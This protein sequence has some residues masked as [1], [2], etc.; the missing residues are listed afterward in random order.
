MTTDANTTPSPGF[1]RLLFSWTFGSLW[2]L[3]TLIRTSL[4]NLL[5]LLVIV[6]VIS[7]LRHE[8]TAELPQ[9]TTLRL[10]PS[11]LLVDQRSY[12][13]P[14]TQLLDQVSAEDIETPVRDLVTAINYA[15]E[16]PRITALVLEPDALVGG[17]ISKLE[18]VG[19]ALQ[20]F[21]SS[22]KPIIARAD[23]FSQEQYYLA[24]YADEIILNPLGSVL[25]TGYSSYRN[26]FKTA[27]D[28]L[29]INYHVFRAGSYKDAIEPYTRDD[30]SIA[31]RE[32]N[33]LWL[34]Q[35]WDV[36][37]SRIEA[38]RKLPAGSIDHYI[39]EL[40]DK[41]RASAG[42]SA[43]LALQ[44]QLIDRIANRQQ[45]RQQLI[46]RFGHNNDGDDYN[47]ID[48]QRYLKHIDR[49]QP[50]SA[51]KIGL[52]V[53]KGM[54]VDGEQPEGNIGGDTFARLLRDARQD[55]NLQA[56]VLRI[57]SG[58]GS[59]FASELI[60]QELASTRAAG[61]PLVVSMGSVA[62]SGGYWIATESDQ[63]WATPTTITGSIGVFGAF[64]TLENTLANMGVY[65]DGVGTT[66]LAGNM[67]L[68]RPLSP[69]AQNVI[70]QSVEFIY[71]QFLQLVAE[72][73][74][75][76]RDEVHTIAQGRVWSGAS[77]HQLALVDELGYLEDAI[78]AAAKLAELEDYRVE[79]L[80]IPLSPS[81]QLLR[82]LASEAAQL[83]IGGSSPFGGLVREAFAPL[84]SQMQQLTRMN[85]PRYI[86]TL[87]QSCSAP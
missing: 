1:I 13:D 61:I 21:K 49:E 73:R 55:K 37:S 85:D 57:D 5:L 35:L 18:E 42:N 81:E 63:V 15:A 83:K 39:A 66:D 87:C 29:A 32:H 27:L 80:L 20:G 64:P 34:N 33:S 65:T 16:D 2:R 79:E 62:A 75:K 23:N 3:L 78:A 38:Q 9:Q 17:G 52:I 28:K 41:L 59:A 19:Q 71:E 58:G 6:I 53:A 43:Q 7:A 8:E 51:N 76:H 60:R 10:A 14:M 4:A 45:A 47:S 50:Q 26:Y 44:Q 36:Y 31:S 82:Q 72:A 11:G 77:A 48:L 12:I 40:D 30:M 70:Q 46:E 86:Y 54:I 74:H 84:L 24:S 67:R 22:G 69:Q 25:L 56:L 68:D